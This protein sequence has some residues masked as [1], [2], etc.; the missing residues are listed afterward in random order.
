M[1]SSQH[2]STTNQGT[3][4]NEATRSE[5]SNLVWELAFVGIATTND[6]AV[7]GTQ[8]GMSDWLVHQPGQAVTNIGGQR[9]TQRRCRSGGHANS[10]QTENGEFHVSKQLGIA[11]SNEEEKVD[12]MHPRQRLLY[13]IKF[14]K[15]RLFSSHEAVKWSHL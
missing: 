14:K 15:G 3:T 9:Q 12:S 1:S 5:K 7:L 11:L 8:V 4:A 13:K 10:D 6:H 2:S